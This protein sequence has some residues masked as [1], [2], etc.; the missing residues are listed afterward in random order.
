MINGEPDRHITVVTPDMEI[1]AAESKEEA[2]PGTAD[3]TAVKESN[4]DA[5]ED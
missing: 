2:K 3:E 4:E 5:K 1:S